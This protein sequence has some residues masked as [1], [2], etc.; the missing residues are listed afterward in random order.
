MDTQIPQTS[1]PLFSNHLERGSLTDGQV[2]ESKA[3]DVENTPWEVLGRGGQVSQAL[4]LIHYPQTPAPTPS[5]PP[6]RPA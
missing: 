1:I 2:L 3:Q 6:S 4:P 5:Y